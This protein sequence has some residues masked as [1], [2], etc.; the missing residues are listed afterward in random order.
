[1]EG[2][3][4]TTLRTNNHLVEIAN[5]GKDNTIP[6]QLKSKSS[7]LSNTDVGVTNTTAMQRQSNHVNV[8][9]QQK[10]ADKS[11]PILLTFIHGSLLGDIDYYNQGDN[12]SFDE[13]EARSGDEDVLNEFLTDNNNKK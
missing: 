3:Q 5:L 12:N 6:A 4:Q 13:D 7:L 9:Q 10:Y 11:Y 8:A 1:M 2:H